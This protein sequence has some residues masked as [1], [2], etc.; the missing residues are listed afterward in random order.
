[1]CGF[2]HGTH[3]NQGARQERANGVDVDGKATLDLAV[4]NSGDNFVGLVCGF[5]VFPCL[6]A[7]GLLAGQ[8]GLAETVFNGLQ[9]HL[10]FV[11]DIEC[12]VAS[13]VGELRPG[14][15][16]LGLQARVNGDPLVVDVD[17]HAG[18]DSARLHVD[19]FQTFFKKFSEG[20]AHRI[21]TCTKRR[22]PFKTE[23]TCLAAPPA[24]T[25][26]FISRCLPTLTGIQ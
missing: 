1:M 17:N 13:R 4:D 22:C 26:H 15:N 18:D 11:A 5:E 14:D 23:R 12:A 21:V 8:F 2:A 6:G 19:G 7:L 3:V 25:G 24:G 10:H 16:A 20:F 9:R